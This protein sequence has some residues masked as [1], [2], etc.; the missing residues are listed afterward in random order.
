MITTPHSE[1]EGS[2]AGGGQ[3]FTRGHTAAGDGGARM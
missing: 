2:R 1:A 3:W